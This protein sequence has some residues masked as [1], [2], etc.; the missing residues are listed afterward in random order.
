MSID[1]ATPKEWDEV[2]KPEKKWIKVDVVDKPE[3]YNKGGIEA[4]DYIKQQLGDDFSAYCEGNVHKYIHRY[5][6]KNGVE[7]LRKARVYLEW[8]IK[9]VAL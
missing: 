2:A 9:E 7:D 8:L 3:H 5:K 1:N 6:Y 4:I